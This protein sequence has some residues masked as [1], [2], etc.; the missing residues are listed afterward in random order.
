VRSAGRGSTPWF[1]SPDRRARR[2]RRDC[3][4][5]FPS[6]ARGTRRSA[7]PT[8]NRMRSSRRVELPARG[9]V[10]NYTYLK[11]RD[12]LSYAVR[13]RVCSQPRWSSKE[14]RSKRL[15]WRSVVCR[16]TSLGRDPSVESG[17]YAG[18]G[19]QSG[20]IHPR[21]RMVLLRDRQGLRA[22]RLQDRPSARRAIVRAL[23]QAAA[24]HPPSRSRNKTI[25]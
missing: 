11:I 22:Q 20:D 12:R 1:M 24:R 7:T 2:A 4:F 10:A 15:V 18:P 6:A 21:W 25:R 16:G 14:T 5:G 23:T 17:R 3:A 9:F 19:R 8:C 13:P